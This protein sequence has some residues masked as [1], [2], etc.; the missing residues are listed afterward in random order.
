MF[1]MWLPWLLKRSQIMAYK[2][3]QHSKQ[4]LL[5]IPL[6]FL[7]FVDDTWGYPST[8][9]LSDQHRQISIVARL[10]LNTFAFLIHHNG[11]CIHFMKLLNGLFFK[12]YPFKTSIFLIALWRWH[13]QDIVNSWLAFCNSWLVLHL[14]PPPYDPRPPYL[15]QQ[16]AGTFP[17][18][19]SD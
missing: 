19:E 8:S 6:F 7:K 15:M 10:L 16:H 17:T 4:K 2:L 9:K 1:F 14:W 12:T 11:C 3:Q 13:F 18:G 5:Q